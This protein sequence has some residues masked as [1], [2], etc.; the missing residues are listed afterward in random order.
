MRLLQHILRPFWAWH[1]WRL[2]AV[3]L[4]VLCISVQPLA[5]GIY[6]RAPAAGLSPFQ[7]AGAWA[8]LA[9]LASQPGVMLIQ[10]AVPASEAPVPDATCSYIGGG[11]P[12]S[13]IASPLLLDKVIVAA[14]LALVGAILLRRMPRDA[15]QLPPLLRFPPPTPPPIAVIHI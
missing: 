8:K 10:I 1:H 9:A 3:L 14:A 2:L 15:L 12:H 5:S 7:Q 6:C 13:A 11:A 4:V